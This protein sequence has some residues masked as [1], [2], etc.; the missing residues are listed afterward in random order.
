VDLNGFLGTHAY[1]LKSAAEEVG[2]LSNLEYLFIARQPQ[3]PGQ[4]LLLLYRSSIKSN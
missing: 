1:S 3:M 2:E 4:H